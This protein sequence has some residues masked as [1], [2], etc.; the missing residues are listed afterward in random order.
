MIELRE[1]SASAIESWAERLYL[2]ARRRN[3]DW[4]Q[5]LDWFDLDEA[6]HNAYRA[7]ALELLTECEN[8]LRSQS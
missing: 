8:F 4:D 7:E 1:T 3:S 6:S 2:R 5:E